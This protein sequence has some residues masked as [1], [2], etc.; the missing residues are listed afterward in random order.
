MKFLITGGAGF[1]G[2]HLAKTLVAQG[3]EV[4]VYDTLDTGSIKNLASIRSPGKNKC[5]LVVQRAGRI[6]RERRIYDAVFHLGMPSSSPIY[7]KNPMC[8]AVVVK[9]AI[10]ILEYCRRYNVPLIYASTSSLYNG[11]QTPFDEEQDIYIT[12]YYTEARYAL[13]RLAKLYSILH[14]VKSVGLRYFSVY[15]DGEESKGRYANLISQFLWD[16]RKN[17][18]PVIYGDGEQTR[19]FIHVEDVVRAN[20]EAF[21][22]LQLGNSSDIF[23]VGTGCYHSLNQ[24]V[25]K[26]NAALKKKIKPD[27]VKNTIPNYVAR[28][29]ASMMKTGHVLGFKAEIKLDEGIRRLI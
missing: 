27:Y 24:V 21:Q 26:L 23:N 16:M 5:V 28:T 12:D 9:D 22:Y 14:G 4:K 17:K 15:G 2:S 6:I 1:V 3:H 20:M 13:E 18:A 11:N 8:V 7:K 29:H 19:D 25:E 10:N